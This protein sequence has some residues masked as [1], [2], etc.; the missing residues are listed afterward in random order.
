MT[1][2]V[3][4]TNSNDGVVE[5]VLNFAYRP[6]QDLTER[7]FQHDVYER[8]RKNLDTLLFGF[9]DLQKQAVQ[10][11]KCVKLP[12]KIKT[13]IEYFYGILYLEFVGALKDSAPYTSK[14][15][16][17]EFKQNP[18]AVERKLLSKL[19]DDKG[20]VMPAEYR[21]ESLRRPGNYHIEMDPRY[22]M[23]RNCLES[24]T[25]AVFDATIDPDKPVN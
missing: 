25:K 13:S 21:R 3:L 10:L 1:N 5:K 24:I 7:I 12:A 23:L 14:K 16:L 15:M 19:L 8:K 11:K 20:N 4:P 2:N 6:L 18:S 22:Q 17:E 9:C